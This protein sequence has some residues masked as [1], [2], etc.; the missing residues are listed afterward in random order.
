MSTKTCKGCGWVYP[1]EW[2]GRVCRFCRTE[3]TDGICAVCGEYAEKLHRYRCKK[4][5]T[6]E[7]TDWRNNRRKKAEAQYEE[8]LESIKKIPEPYTTLSEEQWLDACKH[9]GG[10]AYCGADSIEARSMFIAFKQGGRYC[11]WNIVPSCE[12]CETARKA[13]S[14]PFARMDQTLYRDKGGTAKKYGFTLDNLQRIIDYL[15]VKMEEADDG[16]KSSSV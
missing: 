2:P 4:C 5:S 3:F 6:K 9:F 7:H 11:A 14:N 15:R 12:R 8:W 16:R 13:V 10:C 1:K